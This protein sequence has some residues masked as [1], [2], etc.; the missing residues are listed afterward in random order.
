VKNDDPPKKITEKRV[1]T[2]KKVQNVKTYLI[3]NVFDI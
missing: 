2:T 1:F 3:E